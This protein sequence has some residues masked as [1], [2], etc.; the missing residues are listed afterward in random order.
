MQAGRTLTEDRD[1]YLPNAR[2]RADPIAS[3]L[4][5]PDAWFAASPDAYVVLAGV[6]LLLSEGRAYADRLKAAGKAVEV[7][8]FDDLPHLAM[9]MDGVLDRAREWNLGICNYIAGRFGRPPVALSELYEGPCL[10]A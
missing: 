4:R 10:P 7:V 2:D 3:P 9:A 8:V 6:D 1:Q 5:A